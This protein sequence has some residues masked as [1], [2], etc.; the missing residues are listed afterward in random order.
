[1]WKAEKGFAFKHTSVLG[2]AFPLVGARKERRHPHILPF[3]AL[4]FGMPYQ[5]WGAAQA[6]DPIF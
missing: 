3:S 1:M 4:L 5:A 6:L 2:T